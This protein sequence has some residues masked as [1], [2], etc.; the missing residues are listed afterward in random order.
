MGSRDPESAVQEALRRAFENP[1]SRHAVE[2]YLH[3]DP[4]S[5]FAEPPAW[6][7]FEL[8]R[9]LHGVVKHVVFEEHARASFSREV[10]AGDDHAPD[11]SDPSP[12]QLHI[13]IERQLQTIVQECLS[14]LDEKY[15]TVLELR[16]R[17]LKYSE[18]AKRLGESEN[19]VA[20]WVSRGTKAVTERVRARMYDLPD[21]AALPQCQ[22]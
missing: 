18:I 5:A 2:Y 22:E 21:S 7:F 13:L 4:Y 9:W 10:L 17:G 15:R 1:L 12:D 19:T 8:L 3:D 20:T 14:T 11:M 6:P 16:A